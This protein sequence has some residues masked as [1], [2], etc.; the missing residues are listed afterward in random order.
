MVNPRSDKDRILITSPIQTEARFPA[1]TVFQR[2]DWN[3]QGHILP[4][5]YAKCFVSCVGSTGAEPK[6]KDLPQP[7]L[8]PNQACDCSENWS[9]PVVENFMWHNTSYRYL[10]FI[11]S[12]ALVSSVPT[13]I[14]TL[15][16]FFNCKIPWILHAMTTC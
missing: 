5:E 13:V 7:T 8:V 9:S 10:S 11:P 14:M 2:L 6:C 4:V 12:A 1:V 15:Q 3:A 16:V